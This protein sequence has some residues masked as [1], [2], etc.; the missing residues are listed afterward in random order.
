MVEPFPGCY[1]GGQEV[2]AD[3]PRPPPLAHLKAWG[4]RRG[5]KLAA[6]T[7]RGGGL[8][9][10]KEP[11]R[12]LQD[13]SDAHFAEPSSRSRDCAATG[14]THGEPDTSLALTMPSDSVTFATCR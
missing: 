12:V 14:P 1:E 11:S 2:P 6:N 3:R 7:G 4:A 5:R 8:D 9:C 10:P 13:A